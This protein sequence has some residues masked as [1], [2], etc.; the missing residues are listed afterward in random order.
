MNLIINFFKKII[1]IINDNVNY[2]YVNSSLKKEFIQNLN[3]DKKNKKSLIGVIDNIS[4]TPTF[5]VLEFLIYLKSLNF[6]NNYIIILPFG[7]KKKTLYKKQ[8]NFINS[9]EELRYKTI[10]EPCLDIVKNFNKNIISLSDRYKSYNFLDKKKTKDIILPKETS[11]FNVS[12]VDYNSSYLKKYIEILK[13]DKNKKVYLESP[14][15]MQE[16]VKKYLNYRK[17]QKIISISLKDAYYQINRNSKLNEW[18]K[19]AKY[20][21]NLGYRVIFIQDISTLNKKNNIKQQLYNYEYFDIFSYD[22]RA[23]LALYEICDLNCSISSGTNVLLFHSNV[24]YL[25]FS[26]I[27]EKIKSGTGS[28]KLWFHH[29]GVGRNKQ[30]PFAS[31]LQRIVWKKNNEKFSCMKDEFIKFKK[32]INDNSKNKK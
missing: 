10:L 1:Y 6:K 8:E 13:K 28:Y 20:L 31:N 4:H 7:K 25:L 3:F 5:I 15:Y 14:K 32:K 30:F 9:S 22:I 29:T 23:R 27:N 24:N 17:E 21:K 16:F 2:Y 26:V 19:F 11:I 12:K 18:L